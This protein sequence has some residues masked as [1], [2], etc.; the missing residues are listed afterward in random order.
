MCLTDS[1]N[2]ASRK[3]TVNV[4]QPNKQEPEVYKD[5]A[6]LKNV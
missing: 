5:L 6:F 1:N 3:L 4:P 2:T